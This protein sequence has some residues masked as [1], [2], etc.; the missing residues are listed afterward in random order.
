[1][2]LQARHD[3]D[4]DPVEVFGM[5]TGEAFLRAKLNARG[6]T[7]IQVL[8]CGPGPGG[9]RI[10]TRR[11]VALDLPGFARRFLRP[12]NTVTQTDVWSDPDP[13]GT[14][15]GTWQVEASGVPVTMTGTMTL[16][17][18][19]RHSIEDID[20][21]VSSAVPFVGGQLAAFIGRAAA[22]NLSAEHAFARRWLADRTPQK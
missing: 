1:M 7:D 21:E 4:A 13:A 8:D 22:D 9:F 19:S 15:T 20:G 12:A 11:T 5:L 6:D 18:T 2:R 17:G 16:T 3:Y 14:R 10:V